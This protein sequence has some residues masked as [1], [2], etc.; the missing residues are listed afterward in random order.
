[1]PM[2][3]P[4]DTGHA[5]LVVIPTVALPSVLCETFR[6]IC[7]AQAVDESAPTIAV[8]LAVN[9]PDKASADEAIALCRK[10]AAETPRLDLE[11]TEQAG[12]IG[13][14]AANNRG[15]MA[16][17]AKWGGLPDLVVFHNDDAH[18]PAGW[19][20]GLL[21]GLRTDTVHGYSEPWDVESG[22]SRQ[23][24]PAHLYGKIGLVGPSSNLVAGIQILNAIKLP[25]GRAVQFR[26]ETNDFAPHVKA[27]YGGQRVTADFLSGFCVGLSRE[28]IADLM[29]Q[30]DA[31][32]AALE[33]TDQPGAGAVSGST[34]EVLAMGPRIVVGPWDEVT[35]PIAGYEDNDLC[36]RAELAGWRAVVVGD[37]FVGHVG[38]QTFDRLFPDA[39]RGMRN[40][41]AYY[42]RWED[43]T[44]KDHRLIWAYRLKF[45]VCHDIHLMRQ[46]LARAATL[47]DGVAIVLTGNPLEVQGDPNWPTEQGFVNEIDADMLNGCATVGETVSTAVAEG[48]MTE[49]EA[50]EAAARD[51]A[52]L[53]R[54]WAARWIATIPGARWGGG[55]AATTA[56]RIKV[57]T[58]IGA[59][60]ERDERNASHA[61]AEG[62][63]ADWILSVDSDEVV[64]NR[65]T[66]E[67]FDRLMRFP[68]P[69][70]RSW[71]QSWINHWDSAR[72]QRD[73]RP[74]GDGGSYVGGMHGY[75]LWRVPRPEDGSAPL[76]PRRI[77]AGTDNGLHCGNSPDH[78]A[79]AKRVSG[80]RF[81]H[82]GYVRVQDRARKHRRYKVQDPT[83]DP[84]LTGGSGK[85]AYAHILGEEGMRISPFSPINGIGLHVLMHS[86]ETADNLA[87]VLD[88]VYGVVDRVVLVWTEAW[89]PADQ[90]WLWPVDPEMAAVVSQ[91]ETDRQTW[92]Q[93]AAGENPPAPHTEPP[94]L[95]STRKGDPDAIPHGNWK[96]GPAVDVA[97][98]AARFGAEWV[99]QPLNDDL[100]AAR[101]AGL[102]ALHAK[103]RGLG[104]SI[105]WDL[106]EYVAD[107]FG[108]VIALRRMAETTDAHG[109]LIAFNNHH[110]GQAPSRS[111]SIRMVRLLPDLRLTGR[112][113]ETYDAALVAVRKRGADVIIRPAPFMV[114]HVGLASEDAKLDAK[115]QRYARLLHLELLDR[116]HNTTAWV[117]LA[118]HYFN[119]GREDLGV[120]CLQRAVL[121]SDDGAYLAFRE[122]A[123]WH[124]RKGRALLGEAI[125]RLGLGNP[126]S[127]AMR[128]LLQQ[129][130]QTVP[131][132]PLLGSARDGKRILPP[133]ELP[134]FPVPE[135][136]AGIVPAGALPPDEDH[137]DVRLTPGQS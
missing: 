54:V 25:D 103:P 94:P 39:L 35:Y 102:E 80:I 32:G 71:D 98:V 13:F 119:E 51:V 59:F 4:A 85:D 84:M 56:D 30:V 18:V 107:P 31:T 33:P 96:T 73:D 130:T 77:L 10:M 127:Q 49:A 69:L 88:L 19:I 78:D 46:S 100:A 45:E 14:G 72:L 115:L 89:D 62:L 81:R 75:R 23:G 132:M 24:R 63:G 109:W 76:A 9:S 129:L 26:G 65:V 68:D 42:R 29:L 116:P 82:F 66:R 99:H 5:A 112:V 90:A 105:F 57:E 108:T 101:N 123:V 64:E 131:D 95:R 120:E 125:T 44:Q 91:R 47:A 36:M 6:R 48:K 16:A 137:G 128:P 97:E 70:V 3:I 1:M 136:L 28:C 67:H 134:P 27:R 133:V 124:L 34:A 61:L 12:P 87:R 7:A 38:H 60:N 37:V 8:V 86:G 20:Q 135:N 55:D 17:I 110:V 22:G 15:L 126:W 52:E 117:A 21:D 122:M 40:R 58:W 104:W 11:I 113:H 93:A 79:T 53:V 106:D 114:D 92:A 41:L 118:L 43:Y 2:Q 74:W 83:P 50:M 121:C 111:E